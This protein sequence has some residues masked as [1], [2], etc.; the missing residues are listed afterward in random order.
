MNI[1]EKPLNVAGIEKQ[2]KEELDRT[3]KKYPF[4]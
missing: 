3:T 1:H 4:K 2:T